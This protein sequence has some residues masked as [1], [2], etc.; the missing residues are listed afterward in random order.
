[1]ITFPNSFQNANGDEG[2]AIGHL[3]W[4]RDVPHKYMEVLQAE[5]YVLFR[6]V[7]ESEDQ[8]Y[9]FE[10]FRK[11]REFR[12]T[13]AAM[14]NITGII[15]AAVPEEGPYLS[16]SVWDE[17]DGGEL[18]VAMTEHGLTLGCTLGDTKILKVRL[19]AD[20]T[21]TLYTLL[22]AFYDDY[23]QYLNRRE[24]LT[25]NLR[26]WHLVLDQLDDY[27][28]A[29][30]IKEAILESG[31]QNPDDEVTVELYDASELERIKDMMTIEYEWSVDE[32]R[33]VLEGLKEIREFDLLAHLEDGLGFF[34]ETYSDPRGL[35][36]HSLITARLSLVESAAVERAAFVMTASGR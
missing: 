32:W 19:D 26:E 34:D 33:R 5:D 10:Q 7:H 13:V 21:D 3:F 23:E 24:F 14:P 15:E 31:A 9:G 6:I 8:R 28:P 16:A 27:Y 1:M 22:L 12:V 30:D 2:G 36:G 18:G 25:A 11:M 17:Y 35:T 4:D 20:A 29:R